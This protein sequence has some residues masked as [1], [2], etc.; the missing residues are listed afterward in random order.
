MNF[1]GAVTHGRFTSRNNFASNGQFNFVGLNNF[2]LGHASQMQDGLPNT[3]SMHETFLNLYFTDTWKVSSRLTVNAGIRWEPYLPITV[4]TG[5]IF[6][7]DI[8]RY[9]GGNKEHAVRECA[10]RILLS[11][12]S[13]LPGQE[14]R[15]YP[16]G[17]FRAAPGLRMGS[18]RRRQDFGPRLLRLRLCLRAWPD[19]RRP[20]GPKSLGRPADSDS[21]R[22][23][24]AA[25]VSWISAIPSEAPRTTRIPY[26]I[27]NKNLTFTPNGLFATTPYDTPSPT[28]STWNFADPAADRLAVAG[29]GNLY[30]QQGFA[31]LHQR[32]QELRGVRLRAPSAANLDAR[33]DLRRLQSRTRKVLL[34]R[35][36]LERRRQSALRRVCCSPCNAAWRGMSA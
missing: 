20:A 9:A 18:L 23:N 33:R 36:G 30:G 16:M 27:V 26:D 21:S 22:R 15:V 5:V 7:F 14:R 10:S 28:Y 32:R 4:P 19:S 35:D 12:R 1:G 13:R 29:F 31:P 25:W 11:G 8:N 24:P 3:Q 17:E 2:L 34:E 6:N